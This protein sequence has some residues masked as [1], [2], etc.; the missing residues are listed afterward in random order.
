MLRDGR[1][2]VALLLRPHDDLTG[3]D[4]EELLTEQQVV[5]LP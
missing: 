3:Q 5:L 2:D 1:A 4:A